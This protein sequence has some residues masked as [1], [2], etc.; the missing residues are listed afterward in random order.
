MIPAASTATSVTRASPIIN[1]DAVEAVRSGLRLEFSR[2]SP[3]ATPPN[4]R[5]GQPSTAASG[6]TS[7][8]ESSETPL[9]ISRAPR[10]IQRR[11]PVVPRPGPK[12]PKVSAA[13][14]T[15]V[16]TSAAIGR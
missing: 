3:P 12:R 8:Y 15:I 1:A 6:G 13:N 16:V 2:A 5:A 14:P 4:R 9:K 10:P 7:L 11:M